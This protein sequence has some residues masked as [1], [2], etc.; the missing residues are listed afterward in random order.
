MRQ[1]FLLLILTAS[2]CSC[3]QKEEVMKKLNEHQIT[4]ELLTMNLKD[5]D[6]EHY[7]D[8]KNTSIN[9]TETKIV[10]S[11]FDPSKNIGERWILV[12]VD[13]ISPS[14]KEFKEFDKHHNTKHKGINGKVDESSWE[15][16][17]DDEAYLIISFKYDKKS[18][19]KKFSFLGDCKGLA[20]YNKKTGKL[21]KTEF[22]NEKPFTIKM[23]NV[24]RLDMVVRYEFHEKEAIYLIDIEE[25]D[26]EVSLLGQLVPINEVNEYSNYRK[27]D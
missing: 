27:I 21:E 4:G 24:T 23:Y 19:P 12:S 26:M 3:T 7:F 1:V 18:L 11:I 9:G 8:L 2:L 15:I 16:E 17:R 14:T 13:Q 10:E 22:V 6:A 5:S 25:L 20:Y